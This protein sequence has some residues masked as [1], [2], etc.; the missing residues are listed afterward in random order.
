MRSRPDRSMAELRA[1]V[2]PRETPQAL[3]ESNLEKPSWCSDRV[4]AG[5]QACRH[6]AEQEIAA[7]QSQGLRAEPDPSVATSGP[8]HRRSHRGVRPPSHTMWHYRESISQ[9]LGAKERQ[10]PGRLE[11]GQ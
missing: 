7:R 4:Q 5:T 6:P 8:Q 9:A 1:K 3:T 2:V 10:F 11:S